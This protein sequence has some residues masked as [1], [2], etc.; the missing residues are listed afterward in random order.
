MEPF[1]EFS[2]R[3]AMRI[4]AVLA[5]ITS[6]LLILVGCGPTQGEEDSRAPEIIEQSCQVS[7]FTTAGLYEA[8]EDVGVVFSNTAQVDLYLLPT[9]GEVDTYRGPLRFYQ[10]TSL[11]WRPVFP[12]RTTLYVTPDQ[13]TTVGAESATVSGVTGGIRDI[14]A[15]FGNSGAYLARIEYRDSETT[16]DTPELWQYSNEFAV[17][18]PQDSYIVPEFEIVYSVDESNIPNFHMGLSRNFSKT[19]GAVTS[20]RCRA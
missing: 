16:Q 14:S 1:W 3:V 9:E 10:R 12:N 4:I 6:V 18:L 2:E 7:L 13:P 8:Y 19:R 5:F 11:G 15:G 17:I 20:P